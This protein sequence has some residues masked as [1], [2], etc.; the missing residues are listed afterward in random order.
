MET[1]AFAATR[2]SLASSAR[3]PQS[4][5]MQSQYIGGNLLYAPSETV[6]SAG[7]IFASA[8]SNSASFCFHSAT[9]SA[10]PQAS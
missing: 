7:S 1:P 5:P 3:A 9:L 8:L 10:L 2:F 4:S 6:C